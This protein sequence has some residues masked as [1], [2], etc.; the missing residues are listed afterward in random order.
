LQNPE[1]GVETRVRLHPIFPLSFLNKVRAIIGIMETHHKDEGVLS[2]SDFLPEAPVFDIQGKKYELKIVRVGD[3]P[4]L[5]N[6]YGK[7][8]SKLDEAFKN[9]DW[10]EICLV[11]FHFLKDKSDFEA[12]YEEDYDDDGVKKKLFVTGPVRLQRALQ[13]QDE[14]I[15]MLAA[16]VQAIVLGEPKLKP[17]V[18]AEVKKNLQQLQSNKTGEK[19]PTNLPMNTDTP[20]TTSPTS[21]IAS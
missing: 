5:Q 17:L 6:R 18:E 4:W 12:I 20:P 21:P 14:A 13:T 11:V 16:M 19:L 10:A 1:G 8:L 9:R 15:L 7:D 2:L 3:R